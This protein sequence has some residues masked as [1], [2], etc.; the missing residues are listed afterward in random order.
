MFE[1]Y[2]F[3][4][5][6]CYWPVIIDE[7]IPLDRQLLPLTCQTVI[8]HILIS[9]AYALGMLVKKMKALLGYVLSAP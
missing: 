5:I 9:V 8:E 1:A 4:V 2:I 3:E 7:H 6:A